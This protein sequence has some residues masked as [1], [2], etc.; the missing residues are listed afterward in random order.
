MIEIT[1]CKTMF[2]D[3]FVLFECEFENKC[4]YSVYAD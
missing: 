3:V 4:K 2:V 1:E